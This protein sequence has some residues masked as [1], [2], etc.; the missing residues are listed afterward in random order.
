MLRNKRKPTA[1]AV[2]DR[3]RSPDVVKVGY[4]MEKKEF[5][6]RF[7]VFAFSRLKH[8]TGYAH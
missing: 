8:A 4:E 3:E 7:S 2:S 6:E 5:R 1:K